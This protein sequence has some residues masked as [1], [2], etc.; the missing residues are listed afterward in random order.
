MPGSVAPAIS[1]KGKRHVKTQ[2][3]GLAKAGGCS[4]CNQRQNKSDSNSFHGMSPFQARGLFN[5]PFNQ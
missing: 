4:E 3:A 2:A 5:F 1:G